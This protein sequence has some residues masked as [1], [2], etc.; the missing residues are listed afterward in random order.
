MRT[1]QL[2][3]TILGL[4]LASAASGQ[5]THMGEIFITGPADAPTVGET[6]TMEVWGRFTSPD[7]VQGVSAIAGFGIDI[8]LTGDSDPIASIGNVH[9]SDWASGFGQTGTV[10]GSTL[11]GVSGGQ[12][13]NVFNLNPSINL[14]NPILLFTF[15]FTAQP[16][17]HIGFTPMNPNPNGGLSFYPVSTAGASVTVPN[18]PDSSLTLSEFHYFVPA[19]GSLAIFTMAF[20]SM[21]HRR[22]R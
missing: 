12:L 15:D 3:A 6:Y 5:A 13:A 10:D 2:Y 14:D 21:A 18:N 22:R 4:G 19:P 8:G 17:T 1:R 16:Y 20:G 7:F 9:I 11:R